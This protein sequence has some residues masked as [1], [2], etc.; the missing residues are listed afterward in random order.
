M[1]DLTPGAENLFAAKVIDEVS[2]TSRPTPDGRSFVAVR[3]LRW[4]PARRLTARR[5]SMLVKLRRLLRNRNAA[6]QHRRLKPHQSV[7]WTGRGSRS[8]PSDY[9]RHGDGQGPGITR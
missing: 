9:G 6:H 1:F 7:F 8:G 2:R 4:L 3:P 5:W